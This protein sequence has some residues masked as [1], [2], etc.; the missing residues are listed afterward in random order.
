MADSLIIQK[1]IDEVEL[2]HFGSTEQ[3]LEIHE[4]VY[5]E[6]QPKVLRV[7]TDG[8][9]GS[10][11]VY[12]PIKNEKFYL[13]VYL[14]TE[15]NISVRGVGTEAYH[16]VHFSATSETLDF[17]QLS[18]LTKLKPTSGWS[19]GDVRKSRKS[20]HKFSVFNF[21]PN[22]EPD[23]FEDK[24]KKL[25]DALEQDKEGVLALVSQ[26]D[27]FIQVASIFHNGNTMLGGHHISKESV[28]RM[29]ALEL[30]IDFD[31]YANGNFFKD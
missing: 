19:K 20:F 7:D 22:P 24:L 23:E 12:F 1:A 11:I 16:S 15:P 30:T 31:L 2:K 17:E 14:D 28:K 27:V 10:A 18:S 3:L 21:E 13:A 9:D 5:E 4:V 29:A 6:N 25:V 26:A 8:P